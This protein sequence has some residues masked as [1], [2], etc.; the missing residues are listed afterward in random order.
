[1]EEILTEEDLRALKTRK[2]QKLKNP[3]MR[4]LVA[5]KT[6]SNAHGVGASRS[7]VLGTWD[8]KEW[9]QFEKFWGKNNELRAAEFIKRWKAV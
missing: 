7:V 2:K 4:L 9:L 6:G 8:G 5:S 1:M 3:S